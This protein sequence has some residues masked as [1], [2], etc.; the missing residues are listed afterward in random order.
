[1]PC[2]RISVT[3]ENFLQILH[4]KPNYSREEFHNIITNITDRNNSSVYSVLFNYSDNNFTIFV[5][6]KSAVS[7][8]KFKIT[9]S[10]YYSTIEADISNILNIKT[11]LLTFD[12]FE[13]IDE[14]YKIQRKSSSFEEQ[15]KNILSYVYDNDFDAAVRCIETLKMIFDETQTKYIYIYILSHLPEKNVQIEHNNNMSSK[16]LLNI[17]VTEIQNIKRTSSNAAKIDVIE[18]ACKFI[19]DNFAK[20]IALEDVA[21]HVFLS[22]IYFSSYFKKNTGEK[23]SD[24]LQNVKLEKACEL[25]K[26]TNVKIPT[27]AEMSGFRDTNYFHK[28]FKKHSGLTPSEYRK[29]Y[30]GE[31]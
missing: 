26:D 4:R 27:I 10:E 20:D 17:L 8:D 2:G 31:S 14:F 9:A 11:S 7:F 21:R 3:L 30:R 18:K 28:I 6:G 22:P 16:T 1:L 13:N 15:A 19:H 29:K 5:F 23:Y 12:T 24:Y 25:L